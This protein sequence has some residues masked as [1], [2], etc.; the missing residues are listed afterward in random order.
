MLAG[1]AES[2]IHPLAIGG[3]ARSRSLITSSNNGPEKSSRPFDK[4][5][6]GFV[7]GEGAGV[8]VLEELNH[9]RDR[10]AEIYAEVVGYGTSADAHHLTAPLPDGNGAL[11]AMKMALRHAG[12]KPADVDYINAHAT[13]TVLGDAAENRAIEALM[14]GVDGREDGKVNVSSTKGAIGHLLGAAGAVEA[15]FAVLAIKEVR[16]IFL[17]CLPPAVSI[18]YYCNYLLCCFN[19]LS[20]PQLIILMLDSSPPLASIISPSP[21]SFPNPTR[22]PPASLLCTQPQHPPKKPPFL[23]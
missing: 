3:F 22:P 17:S 11:R 4:D 12:C 8:M 2:C 9:A 18:P 13:S 23:H 5:R 6:N 19:H 7:I 14:Q 20:L 15:M 10:G 1:G 21:P 16:F